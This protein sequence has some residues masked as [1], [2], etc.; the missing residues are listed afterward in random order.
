MY[1]LIQLL[2]KLYLKNFKIKLKRPK[3]Y[4]VVKGRKKQ[5]PIN[6]LFLKKPFYSICFKSNYKYIQVFTSF[7]FK[8]LLGHLRG[9]KKCLYLKGDGLKFIKIK[10]KLF[11]KLESS[12]PFFFNIPKNVNIFLKNN[13][14]LELFSFNFFSLN[15]FVMK[16]VSISKPNR[17][18]NKGLYIFNTSKKYF[19]VIKK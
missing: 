16:L 8:W 6:F 11:L 2:L 9:Y 17:Y 3:V 14:Y 19:K 5:I 18:T 12:R 1:P 4:L 10:K 15:L 7:F 13:Y